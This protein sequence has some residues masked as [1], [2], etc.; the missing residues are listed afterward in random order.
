MLMFDNTIFAS[1]IPQIMMV[2]GFLSVIIAPSLTSQNKPNTDKE[3]ALEISADSFENHNQ[4]SL[5]H[6]RDYLNQDHN[7]VSTENTQ[8]LKIPFIKEIYIPFFN[9]Q[10]LKSEINFSLFSRPPPY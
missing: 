8:T 5:V 1:L 7:V 6:F 4:S 9:I 10:I 2:L 3:I